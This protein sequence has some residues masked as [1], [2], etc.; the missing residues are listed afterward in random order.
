MGKVLSKREE[1][2][3]GHY[4]CTEKRRARHKTGVCPHRSRGVQHKNNWT[5]WWLVQWIMVK[6]TMSLGILIFPWSVLHI[7]IFS[8]ITWSWVKKQGFVCEVQRACHL[9]GQVLLPS[10]LSRA[11]RPSLGTVNQRA[12]FF[13]VK[14]QHPLQRMGS[15]YWLM[16][17]SPSSPRFVLLVCRPRGVSCCL[18]QY[19]F[20]VINTIDLFTEQTAS[21]NTLIN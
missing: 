11:M 15:T 20:W 12:T 10:G 14:S 19:R 5:T 2:L 4:G 13:I 7:F 21:K 9:G 17:H 8:K 1:V 6:G 18:N 16:Q 3:A